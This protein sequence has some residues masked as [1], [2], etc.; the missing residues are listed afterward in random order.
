MY[1]QNV[2][3]GLDPRDVISQPRKFASAVLGQ[4]QAAVQETQSQARDE[5]RQFCAHAVNEAQHAVHEA[6]AIARAAAATAVEQ[7]RAELRSEVR[8]RELSFQQKESELMAQVRALQSEVTIHGHESLLPPTSPTSDSLNG[9]ELVSAIAELRAEVQDLRGSTIS[10]QQLNIP[11]TRG[12]GNSPPAASDSGSQRSSHR[13]S[14][15]RPSRI[16]VESGLGAARF[17]SVLR[18]AT[19]TANCR[20]TFDQAESIS[21]VVV[22]WVPD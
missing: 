17:A 8:Q 21:T 18:F 12:A 19:T 15:R 9:A 5:A 20:C 7:A 11:L 22:A 2:S 13:S 14:G 6:R 3:V 10:P 4:E 1:Q 16:P